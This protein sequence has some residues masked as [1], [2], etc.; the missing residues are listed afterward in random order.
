MFMELGMKLDNLIQT[1]ISWNTQRIWYKPYAYFRIKRW[2][3]KCAFANDEHFYRFMDS[4]IK[5][6][7]IWKWQYDRLVNLYKGDKQ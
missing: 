1:I 6:N 5:V 4:I 2:I 7:I 3:R